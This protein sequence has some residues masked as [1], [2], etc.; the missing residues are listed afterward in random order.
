[1]EDYRNA[2]YIKYLHQYEDVHGVAILTECAWNE[3]IVMWV[4]NR[5]IKDTV[6]L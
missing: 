1:M 6:H 2:T 3:T 4:N 5:G